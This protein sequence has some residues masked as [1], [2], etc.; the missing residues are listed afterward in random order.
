MPQELFRK[1]YKNLLQSLYI[2]V[3]MPQQTIGK[4]NLGCIKKDDYYFSN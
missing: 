2:Q 1:S 4:N 3:S